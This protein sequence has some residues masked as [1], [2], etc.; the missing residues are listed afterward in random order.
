MPRVR[1][2]LARKSARGV[3]TAIVSID[4]DSTVL[5]AAQLMT[6]R[7]IGGLLVLEGDRL[8]GIFTERDIL[9]RIV[10]GQLVA[11]RRRPRPQVQQGRERVGADDARPVLH[12]EGHGVTP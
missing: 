12:H 9:R 10:G 8:A 3:P 2:L 1:D 5:A 11:A 4:P 6:E 7:G